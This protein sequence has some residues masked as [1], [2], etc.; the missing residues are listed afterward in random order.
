MRK[1]SDSVGLSVHQPL[2][3]S[4]SNS[5]RQMSPLPPCPRRSTSLSCVG[6]TK[7]QIQPRLRSAH[8]SVAGKPSTWIR[9]V[10]NSPQC[11]RFSQFLGSLFACLPAF[12]LA[13]RGGLGGPRTSASMTLL[14]CSLSD[15]SSMPAGFGSCLSLPKAKSLWDLDHEAIAE[16]FFERRNPK[17]VHLIDHTYM[18]LHKVFSLCFFFFRFSF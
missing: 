11:R 18:H 17:K 15:P 9:R 7:Q 12:R 14:R 13:R 2:C 3:S 6:R 10:R 5:I 16:V 4:S 1:T 8:G